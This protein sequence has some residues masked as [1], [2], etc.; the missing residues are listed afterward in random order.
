MDDGEQAADGP[1][2]IS[3]RRG[4]R[5]GLARG[6]PRPSSAREGR[7]GSVALV[8][9]G[10]G[11]PELLTVR[12]TKV[13]AGA[14]ALVHDRLVA[15]PILALAPRAARIYV[16]KAR[17]CHAMPQDAI[18]A[19][20]VRLAREGK[21]VVRL[22]GGDPFIFG[23]GGEE[24]EALA[25]NGIPFEVVPGISAANGVAAS[26]GIPLT[27]R[28]HAQTCLFVTGHLKDGTMDLDWPAL[29]RPRQTV[30]VYMGLLGLPVLCDELIRHGMP[31]STP[32]AVVSQGTTPRQRVVTG[33]IETLP[34]DATAAELESPT[35]IIIGDVVKVRERLGDYVATGPAA[36]VLPFPRPARS[37]TAEPSAEGVM[38]KP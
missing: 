1:P 11:D 36:A 28:D 2:V 31:R 16:G 15:P 37:V 26:A 32:A 9:A 8:G 35:L 13:I 5:S 38:A 25:A 23:R 27:H 24:I 7:V 14:D 34:I 22:K 30:V 21:R 20:L 6:V 33:T 18:N 19:L 12:A 10:P 3:M 4:R 29:A 17:S